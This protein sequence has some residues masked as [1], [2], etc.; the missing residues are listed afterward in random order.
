MESTSEIKEIG[1]AVHLAPNAYRLIKGW[2]GDLIKGYGSVL[3]TGYTEYSPDAKKIVD[4]KFST[5]DAVGTEWV[6]PRETSCILY[7][8][9]DENDEW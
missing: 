7:T 6:S 4:V 8:V 3:C 9:A 5:L 2:G 1:A